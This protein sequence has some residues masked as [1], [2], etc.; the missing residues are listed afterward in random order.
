MKIS[1]IILASFCTLFIIYVFGVAAEIRF[2]GEERIPP[3]LADQITNYSEDCT[4]EHSVSLKLPA[5]KILN[6]N[7]VR[8]IGRIEFNPKAQNQ[9]LAYA[10]SEEQLPEMKYHVSGDTLFIDKP[11]KERLCNQF[12]IELAEPPL[13]IIV[14]SM[15]IDLINTSAGLTSLNL[16]GSNATFQLITLNNSIASIDSLSVNLDNNSSIHS[17]TS[18]LIDHLEGKALNNSQ[19]L[20]GNSKAES[21]DVEVHGQSNLMINRVNYQSSGPSEK[22]IYQKSTTMEK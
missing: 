5:F 11:D 8:G 20:L 13:E 2:R 17:Q 15:K 4:S 12:K 3:H 1:N 10:V 9:F 21:A 18:V 19:I 16:K 7:S 22:I 14:D 6:L